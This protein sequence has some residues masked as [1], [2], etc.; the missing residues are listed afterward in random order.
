MLSHHPTLMFVPVPTH[1]I[2]E[3]DG[4]VGA[5]V[6]DGEYFVVTPYNDWVHLPPL[7]TQ[8]VQQ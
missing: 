2:T 5:V 7:G 6:H 4:Y 8:C 1:P 3:Y